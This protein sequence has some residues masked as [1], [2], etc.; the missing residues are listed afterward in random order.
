[1]TIQFFAASAKAVN[2]PA[3]L[4][5][6]LAAFLVLWGMVAIVAR[7]TRRAQAA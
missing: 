2:W 7:V 5:T 3:R 1:M 4:G 6:G